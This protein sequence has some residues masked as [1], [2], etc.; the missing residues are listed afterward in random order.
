MAETIQKKEYFAISVANRRGEAARLLAELAQAGVNLLAFTGFPS[1]RGKAQLDF[2][3]ENVAV[4]R[5]AAERVGIKLRASKTVFLI[6]GDDQ[7]GAVGSVMQRLADAKINVTAIDAASAGNRSYSG[8]LWV[9]PKDVDKAAS[10]L[11]AR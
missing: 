2:V 7:S 3:P 9:K 8:M 5:A 10:V 1:A 6:Q 11:G 4:F